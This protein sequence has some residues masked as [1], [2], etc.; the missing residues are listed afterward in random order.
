MRMEEEEVRHDVVHAGGTCKT[1]TAGG[2]FTISRHDNQAEQGN[3][4]V[5]TAIDHSGTEPTGYGG[6]GGGADYSNAFTCIPDSVNFRPARITPKPVIQGSQT[7]VVVG[8]KGEEIWPDQYGR[9]KVQFYW[10]REGN[11][12]DKTSC[13]IRCAQPSAGKGWGSM[14]IPRIGQEVVVSYLEGDPDQPL[15]TGVVYNADQMPAYTLPDEKTKSYI[16]TNSSKGG[17]G[18]NELRF[19]DKKDQEQIFMHAERDFDLRVKNESREFVG[20][21]RSLIV[22]TEE[23]P[24]HD[25]EWVHGDKV[26]TSD[27]SM[28]LFPKRNLVIHVGD[29]GSGYYAAEV[30]ENHRTRVHGSCELDVD[31]ARSEKTGTDQSLTVGGDLQEKVGGKHAVEAGQEIHLKSGMKVVI[32]AGMQLTIKGPGGFVDIGPAGVTIQGTLVN[33]NSGG[34]AGTGSGS[35]PATPQRFSSPDPPEPHAADNSK[36]GQKSAPD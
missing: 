28:G 9:V 17:D 7:A 21:Q 11:R 22:G 3:A 30:E 1:F 18:Y 24:T 10:D 23:A 15:I 19:E 14:F 2:K 33:I 26:T 34:A 20:G 35:S 4:F 5:I 8:P 12:D 13:W 31:Q 27:D 6:G 29:G 32:E 16:K 25:Y 36:T